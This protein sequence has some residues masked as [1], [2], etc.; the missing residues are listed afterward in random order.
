MKKIISVLLM[1][2]ACSCM[3]FAPV[4]AEEDPISLTLNGTPIT[5]DVP[6]QIVDDHTLVPLR[7]AFEALGASILWDESTSTV[8]SQM[9]DGTVVSLQIGSSKLFLSGEVID[10]DV[11]AKIIGDRTMIPIRAVAESL[12]CD[13]EWLPDTR[14][15]AIL[16]K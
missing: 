3:L 7:A 8:H 10:L 4:S 9:A 13:V 1:F 5:C 12:K 11:P 16:K 2:L 14:E 6:P 15:V